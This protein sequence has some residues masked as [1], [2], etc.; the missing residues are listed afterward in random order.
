MEPQGRHITMLVMRIVL[1][2][3]V[4]L[5]NTSMGL[6]KCSTQRVYAHIAFVTFCDPTEAIITF[7]RRFF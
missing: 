7:T 4:A 2:G 6:Q 1:T 5:D 3:Y